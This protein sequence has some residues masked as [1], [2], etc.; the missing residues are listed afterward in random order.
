MAYCIMFEF[1]IPLSE[2]MKMSIR[3]KIFY[4][5]CLLIKAD[6]ERKAAEKCQR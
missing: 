6:K 4:Y 3:E 1:H 5:A 2:I